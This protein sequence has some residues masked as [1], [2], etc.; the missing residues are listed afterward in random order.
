MDLNLICK[1]NYDK[2]WEESISTKS[3]ADSF[4]KFKNAIHT[5]PYL[6]K[7]KNIKHK[8]AMSRFRMSNHSL[9]IEIGRH[10]RPEKIERNKRFCYFCNEKVEDEEHFLLI[11]PLYRPQRKNLE[12]VCKESSKNWYHTMT[13]G[14]KFIFIMSNENEEILNRLGSY[15]FN[16]M[17][18][19]DKMIEYFYT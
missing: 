15:I 13:N 3:K 14:Q 9:M 11:C 12:N 17:R 10:V 5:E 19:R 18:L 6:I 2:Y 8:I 1:S 16:S 7:I 4:I